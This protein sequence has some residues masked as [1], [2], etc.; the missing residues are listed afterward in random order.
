MSF[1]KI[2]RFALLTALLNLSY[3]RGA[4]MAC[5]PI[6]DSHHYFNLFV[7]EWLFDDAYSP[8]FYSASEY[9]HIWAEADYP[10][11]NLQSWQS[12]F[13][14]PV[15]EDL[16]RKVLYDAWVEGYQN[17]E[18][19]VLVKSVLFDGAMVSIPKQEATKPYL[20][21]A[22]EMEQLANRPQS[23]WGYQ[24]QEKMDA[25]TAAD[26]ISRLK[27]AYQREKFSF[28]KNRYAYQLLKAYRYTGQLQQ[29]ADLYQK[30][31]ARLKQ[32]DLISYWAMD[33]YGGILL[34]LGKN[35]EGYYHFLRVFREAPS[36]RHSAYYSFNIATEADWQA[37][38]ANCQVPEE[39]ALMHFIRGTKKDVLGLEDMQSMFGLIGN[40]EWVRLIMAREINK[41]EGANFNYYSG[42]PISELIKQATKGQPLFKNR[43]YTDYAGQLLRFATTAY[44]NNRDDGFWALAKGYMEYLLGRLPTAKITLE[45]ARNLSASELRLNEA[46]LLAIQ[47]MQQEAPLSAEQENEIAQ[48][49]VDLFEDPS[50]QWSTIQHNQEFILE[51]LAHRKAQA[52]APLLAR[53]LNREVLST[54]KMNPALEEVDS[55]LAFIRQPSHTKLEMLALKHFTGNRQ[56]WSSFL[57]RRGAALDSMQYEVLDIKGRLLMRDP[58]QLA[59][60]AALF[61]SLPSA[62]NFPL[63]VNPFNMNLN[64]CV[65]CVQPTSAAYTRNSFV[66]KLA[67]IYRIAQES[68]SPTDYYLLG[69]AYY[70]MT[71]FGPAYAVMNYYRSGSSYDGFYDTQPAMQFYDKAMKYATDQELAA[72]ACFMAA[73]AQQKRYYVEQLPTLK[74]DYYYNKFVI[75]GW[76]SNGLTDFRSVQANMRARG[77][78][79]YFRRLEEQYART[80]FFQRA[81]RECNYLNYY[82]SQ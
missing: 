60:A 6:D 27:L 39:K 64:D 59:A 24:G 78:R 69:N 53:L 80:R 19:S 7:P 67:E 17:V 49:L 75:G 18:R 42:R 52:G 20:L 36:R 66:H 37:T 3:G 79:S 63:E 21:L 82:V 40:H 38:Y 15:P 56:P 34:Q 81:I 50:T 47:L 61:D 2:C 76:G 29:A 45:G 25:A 43:E 30:H 22:L 72:Q 73:K 68:N 12:F 14:K 51:L 10:D 46:L 1:P 26:L 41:L 62:Y 44:Y 77:Y 33:H 54:T 4:L 31:F 16:L 57:L 11:A 71:Y 35:G 13:E 70:N 32:K 8:T 28:L 9:H 55:L 23:T 74:D 5:G 65:H 58:A 48:Q